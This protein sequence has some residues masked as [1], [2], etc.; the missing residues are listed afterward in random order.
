MI[1]ISLNLIQPR[2]ANEGNTTT[3]YAILKDAQGV[4]YIVREDKLSEWDGLET[5]ALAEVIRPAIMAGDAAEIE[6]DIKNEI[7]AALLA[8]GLCVE[9]ECG[10][11]FIN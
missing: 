6:S 7:A 5:A 11:L 9:N 2:V 4:A 1:T 8:E 10:T 3:T